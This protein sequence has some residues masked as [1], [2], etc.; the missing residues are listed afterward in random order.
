MDRVKRTFVF[1]F[2]SLVFLIAL[3][4]PY[5]EYVFGS[6]P[7]ASVSAGVLPSYAAYSHYTLYLYSSPYAP[8]VYERI[9]RVEQYFPTSI[10]VSST[11]PFTPSFYL[12]P[13]VG[14]RWVNLTIPPLY[15]GV[16]VLNFTHPSGWYEAVTINIK[17][18]DWYPSARRVVVVLEGR[19]WQFVQVGPRGDLYIWERP[20]ARLPFAGCAAVFNNS[21]LLV[22]RVRYAP[23]EP[24]VIP[25]PLVPSE[26]GEERYGFFIKLSGRGA[27]YIHDAGCPSVGIA[28]AVGPVPN[29]TQY[30]YGVALAANYFDAPRFTVKEMSTDLRRIAVA[31]GTASSY[32][33]YAYW[34]STPVGMWGGVLRYNFASIVKLTLNLVFFSP[35]GGLPE[36]V[37]DAWLFNGTVKFWVAGPEEPVQ[38]PVLPRGIPTGWQPPFYIVADPTGEWGGW[39]A[40][41]S[42]VEETLK[43][44]KT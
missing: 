26:T 8:W 20:A 11:C 44:W 12:P 17:L 22:E 10:Y 18:V 35:D 27:L 7:L 21:L 23:V 31:N 38:R 39:P 19:G 25:P 14:T 9:I 5:G 34:Y 36:R 37:G 4:S 42:V 32:T 43:P 30:K 28:V 2:P 3:T 24:A 29:F 16:C 15:Q 33:L 13:A 40:V 6:G 41:L 1:F